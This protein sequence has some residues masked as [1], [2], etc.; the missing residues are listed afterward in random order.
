[1]KQYYQPPESPLLTPREVADLLR[2][3]ATTVRRWITIGAL[4]AVT[5]PGA[6][7]QRAYRIQRSAIEAILADRHHS[8]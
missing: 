4:P 3:D 6:G 2:V 1:M 8:C 5:L 7:I